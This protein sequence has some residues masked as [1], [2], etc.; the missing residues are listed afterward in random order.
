MKTKKIFLAVLILAFLIGLSYAFYYANTA[1]PIVNGY[2]AKILCSAKFVSNREAESIIKEDLGNYSYVTHNVD[3]NN[4]SVTAS[5]FGLFARKAIY[6]EKLGCTLLSGEYTEE[7]LRNQYDNEALN[8]L[9]NIKKIDLEK[10]NFS[11]IDNKKLNA[12]LDEAF[13][14]NQEG[15]KYTRAVLV[16]YK[17]KILI[18]RYAPEIKPD[19]ALLG[20]SMTKSMINALTGIMIKKNKLRLNQNNLFKEWSNDQRKDITLDQ[21]LRMSSG[22]KFEEDYSKVSD[23]TNMLFRSYD[24]SKIPLEKDLETKPDSKWSYSSGTTN[25]ISKLIRNTINNDKEYLSLPHKELFGKLGM[26]TAIVETDTSGTFIGSSFMY[27]SARDWAKFGQLY[28]QK[29]IWKGEKIFPDNWAKYS[30]TPTPEAEMGKYG[31]QFWLNA[32]N[33]DGSKWKNLPKDIFYP[34]GFESQ[35][36][37]IIPSKQLVIVRLGLTKKEENCN[38]SHLI[39][40]IIAS[41]K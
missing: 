32:G 15:K 41:F 12:T 3:I 29:G 22:L 36:V 25:L 39:Q 33:K 40:G 28:L 35:Y 37:F 34:S 6:R 38:E 10:G 7:N 27:A 26:S 24:I 13:I 30:A 18:E 14:E 17:G 16:L 8:N 11:N 21:L 2:N 23:A 9:G 4:Q 1:L 31:A 5:V 19:T 20:W